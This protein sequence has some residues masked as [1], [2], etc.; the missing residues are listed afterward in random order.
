MLRVKGQFNSSHL[1][2]LL[3]HEPTGRRLNE[4]VGGNFGSHVEHPRDRERV[5][6]VLFAAEHIQVHLAD[7]RVAQF[8]GQ[9]KQHVAGDE[10]DQVLALLLRKVLE[11]R[12]V[13][14]GVRGLVQPGPELLRSRLEPFLD[15]ISGLRL[16]HGWIRARQEDAAQGTNA[17]KA[18]QHLRSTTPRCSDDFLRTRYPR[19][20]KLPVRCPDSEVRPNLP[21]TPMRTSESKDTSNFI[22][23]SA[24]LNPKFATGLAA[25]VVR[26]SGSRH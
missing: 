14:D 4:Y 2:A 21:H 8:V 1:I 18:I 17:E 11:P 16:S 22:N 6:G 25:I 13:F 10:L 15:L 7:K 24:A 12:V 26:T 5:G 20:S 23:S 3:A 19:R 9:H